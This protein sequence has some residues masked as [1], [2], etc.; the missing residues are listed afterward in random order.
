M[1]IKTPNLVIVR[2]AL[3]CFRQPTLLVFYRWEFGLQ[4]P[5]DQSR[6]LEAVLQRE[7]LKL[8]NGASSSARRF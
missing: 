3:K 1:S 6:L 2:G 5:D 4:P 8:P 7:R